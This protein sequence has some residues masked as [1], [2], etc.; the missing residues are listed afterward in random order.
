ML[1]RFSPRRLLAA[2]TKASRLPRSRTAR[3]VFNAQ[4]ETRTRKTR[5]SG[6]FESPASTNSTTW[7]R[8]RNVAV[9]TRAL[10][11]AGV[12]AP[13]VAPAAVRLD[14]PAQSDPRCG[15]AAA[16]AGPCTWRAAPDSGTP[17]DPSARPRGCRRACA[18]PARAG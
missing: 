5:R 14:D 15:V 4:G 1:R 6:D 16:R 17:T 18:L 3:F 8:V 7:A 9:V 2:T 10:N 13:A 11:A 12:I